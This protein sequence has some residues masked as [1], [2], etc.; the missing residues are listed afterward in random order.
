M[1]TALPATDLLLLGRLV[2]LDYHFIATA[3]LNAA[4]PLGYYTANNAT[5]DGVFV[6]E[7][8]VVWLC[9]REKGGREIEILGAT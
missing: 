3:L 2:L 9:V 8:G 7:G 5:L 4:V 6:G 1:Q